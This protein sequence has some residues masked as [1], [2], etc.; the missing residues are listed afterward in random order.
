MYSTVLKKYHLFKMDVFACTFV[1]PIH[2]LCKLTLTLNYFEHCRVKFCTSFPCIP[3]LTPPPP[4]PHPV[5]FVQ[6]SKSKDPN[7][8]TAARQGKMCTE[9]T[10]FNRARAA[11][12]PHS[13]RNV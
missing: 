5:G 13:A 9:I 4:L 8:K 11:Q 12:A 6:I 2:F 10:G 1:T 7:N 3:P